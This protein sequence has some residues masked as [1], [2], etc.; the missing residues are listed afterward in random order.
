MEI[1]RQY[2]KGS[3]FQFTLGSWMMTLRPWYGLNGVIHTVVI[4]NVVI[5]VI[6]QPTF[7]TVKLGS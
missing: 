3:G 5:Y 1:S 6:L 2:A 7:A 4:H